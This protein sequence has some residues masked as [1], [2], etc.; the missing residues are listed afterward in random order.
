M[1]KCRNNLDVHWKHSIV[2][3]K[4]LFHESAVYHIYSFVLYH[5]WNGPGSVSV[6]VMENWSSEISII[7]VL[8]QIQIPHL[9]PL[10]CLQDPRE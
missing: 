10:V 3:S 7:L 4:W 5:N 9:T 6:I 2:V 1:V 8:G